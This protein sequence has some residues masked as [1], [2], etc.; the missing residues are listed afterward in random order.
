MEGRALVTKPT[1]VLELIDASPE[2]IVAGERTS[3]AVSANGDIYTWG[4]GWGGKLGHGSGDSTG[5]PSRVRDSH[6]HAANP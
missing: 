5:A 6:T 4:D 2:Q 1:L 3:A